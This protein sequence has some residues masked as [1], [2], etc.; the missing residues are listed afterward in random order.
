[1]LLLFTNDFVLAASLL[2]WFIIG[3]IHR[4][5]SETVGLA[6]LAKKNLVIYTGLYIAWAVNFL[7]LS[8]WMIEAYGLIGVGY[9]YFVSQLIGS[10]FVAVCSKIVFGFS[11]SILTLKPAALALIVAG[12]SG[13]VVSAEWGK[14]TQYFVGLLILIIWLILSWG[15]GDFRSLVKAGLGKFARRFR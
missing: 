10:I 11:L 4:V 9:A 7:F 3:D 5:F 6:F 1:M 13:F 2:V 8:Y 12:T 14:L 15:D